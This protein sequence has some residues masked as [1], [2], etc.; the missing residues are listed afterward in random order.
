MSE[1]SI[2]IRGISQIGQLNFS[3]RE[4]DVNSCIVTTIPFKGGEAV[5]I[6]F[7]QPLIM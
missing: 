3:L 5:S 2:S 6:S 4:G 1:L 7:N